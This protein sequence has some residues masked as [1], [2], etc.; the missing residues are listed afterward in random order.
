[1]FH[2]HPNQCLLFFRDPD[3][4]FDAA[5][6]RHLLADRGLTVTGDEPPFA[7]RFRDGPT[8]AVGL[9]RGEEAEVLAGR[10]MGR[11]RKYRAAVAG[12]DAYLRISFDDLDAVLDEINTLIDVQATLQDATGGLMYR[13]WN[14]TWAGPDE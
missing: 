12:C 6:L 11:A 3:G 1:M 10:L 9:E 13:S 8:L 2:I 14:R 7:V 5:R 4:V